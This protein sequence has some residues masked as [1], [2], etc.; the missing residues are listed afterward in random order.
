LDCRWFNLV[1]YTRDGGDEWLPFELLYEMSF[2]DVHCVGDEAFAVGDGERTIIKF[3]D[4]GHIPLEEDYALKGVY[5]VDENNGYAV[6]DSGVI[7][8]TN[9]GSSFE[10]VGN[11]SRDDYVVGLNDIYCLDMDTCWA[12]GAGQYV[13]PGSRESWGQ[14]ETGTVVSGFWVYIMQMK[15]KVG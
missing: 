13:Y 1:F 8:M 7:L 10:R 2:W 6:G 12:T 4:E 5:M 9:D 11:I 14:E 3:V 15:M